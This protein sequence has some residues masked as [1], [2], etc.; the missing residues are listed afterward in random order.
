MFG[1]LL[2]LTVAGI[3]IAAGTALAFVPSHGPMQPTFAFRRRHGTSIQQPVLFM[4]LKVTIRI[5]GRKQGGEEWLEEACDMYLTRLK[6]PSG[7][8]VTTEWHK[9][10][11]ALL[12]GVAADCDKNVPVVLLDPL[13]S[14]MTSEKLADNIY[15]WLEKGGSRLV[16]VIGGGRFI[17]S[18]RATT[19]VCCVLVANSP[20]L[21]F[22]AT[23]RRSTE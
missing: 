21:C 14:R 5:V 23:S 18:K 16:F 12:K 2:L 17:P 13:G 6:Q 10:D 19:V 8:E 7:L 9:S 15:Q 1:A 4:G 3:G 22:V 20:V 11:A